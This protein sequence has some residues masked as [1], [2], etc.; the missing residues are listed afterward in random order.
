MDAL[1][2]AAI[3]AH[4][5]FLA[6]DR[7][8]GRDTAS[9][10]AE[11]AAR[12]LASQLE[13]A[14]LKPAGDGGSFL[15]QVPFINNR[16]DTNASHLSVSLN[17]QSQ[18]LDAGKDFLLNGANVAARLSDVPVV[19]AG[20]GIT[21]P[22]FKHD[23]YAGIDVRG[24]LVVVLAG[25]PVSADPAF[26]EGPKDTRYSDGGS[27][28]AL[29]R[30]KG[31]AGMI[32][33]LTGERARR[34]PWDRLRRNQEGTRIQLPG[35]P[36]APFPTLLM[37]SD[38]AAKVFAAVQPS[39]AEIERLAAEGGVIPRLML[40]THAG[41]EVSYQQTAAPAPN[42]LGYVEGSDP[43]LKQQVVIYSAHYDHVGRRAGSGDTIFNG[44]WDNASGTAEVLEIARTFA[45][46]KP[47]P[48]RSVLFLFVTGEEK[49]LLGSEYYTRAPAF[50]I[51]ATA[52]NINLDMTDIFGIG[53][54]LVA[55]GAERST[56]QQSAEAVASELG[57]RLGKD[58]TPDLNV[59]TR[60]DQFSFV[61]VGVPSVFMR[62]SNEHEELTPAAL[63]ELSK[64]KLDTIYHKE[65][66]EF[67]PT[68]SW[69]GMRRH[70]QAA[71]LFGLHVA[72]Q[73]QLPA[74]NQGDEFNR[75]RMRPEP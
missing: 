35:R 74:W 43:A 59:F 64:R 19:F 29:A 60:S 27:K 28:V 69:E 53:K 54:E 56:L 5:R 21:A 52:A 55:Q 73:R 50:P 6:D 38:G 9:Q 4:V 25:E 70:A 65:T 39:W 44:A 1:P 34:Y 12:Y 49:G 2:A 22:E 67:D 66:D 31:A 63:K 75:P 61:R 32:S 16:L 30:G 24:K 71:F 20:Y 18:R 23:D 51:E 10:G 45:R 58:P 46:L 14:G 3:R 57:L 40:P 48:S 8:E 7:L 72:S 17:G 37:R 41:V 42:V 26:F 36:Q 68:W 47:G 62:W 33:V 15:Q 13:Q 11:I